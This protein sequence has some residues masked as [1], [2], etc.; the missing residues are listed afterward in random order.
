MPPH[1]TRHAHASIPASSAS[2]PRPLARDAREF[3]WAKMALLRTYQFRDRDRVVY[4]GV[5]A[6]QCY[7][8][9]AVIRAA[10]LTLQ[11][12]CDELAFAKSTGSR[13]VDKLVAGKLLRRSRDADDRHLIRIVATAKGRELHDRIAEDMI[14]QDADL[15]RKYPPEVRRSMI[16]VLK[17]LVSRARDQLRV[18][19]VRTLVFAVMAGAMAGE[20][21]A[22]Q[23]SGA[24]AITVLTG[25][26]VYPSPDV[27]PIRD[28]V[29]VVDHGKIA[30]V[31]SAG[32]V[33]I[34]PGAAILR[35]EGLTIM[36]GF[37]N[38]GE[39][40]LMA[41]AGLNTEAILATL[42]TTPARV[43]G[44]GALSGRVAP[45]YDADLVVLGGDPAK[46]PAAFARVRYTIR[47]GRIIY[48]AKDQPH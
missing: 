29:V 41:Q 37:W 40:Q 20:H 48:S 31:G 33:A 14:S 17:T 22:G 30:A 11:G 10:G 45:G 8:L 18:L 21:A 5:S 3:F 24:P 4:H 19:A 46:D 13:I 47:T 42:T 7:V 9:A 26:M 43:F 39:Y 27:P 35:C 32:D 1:L 44:G 23:A 2:T 12:L 6:T 25:A 38:A 16:Q 34:P 36:A 28:G 15:L